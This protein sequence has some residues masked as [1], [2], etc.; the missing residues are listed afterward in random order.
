M[1]RKRQTGRAKTPKTAAREPMEQPQEKKPVNILIDWRFNLIVLLC[2]ELLIVVFFMEREVTRYREKV[3]RRALLEGDYERAY[4]NYRR[5]ARRNF[6]HAGYFKGLGDAA[7]GKGQP[8]VAL[9][10][11]SEAAKRGATG[12]LSIQRA[13]AHYMR[14]AETSDPQKREQELMEYQ[15]YLR[16]AKAEAPTGLRENHTIGTFAMNESDLVEAA[17]YFSRVRA[18]VLRLGVKPNREQ[19]A[20]ID[21]S[22]TL[23]SRIVSEVFQDQDYSLDLEGLEIKPPPKPPAP[24]IGPPPAAPT[25]PTTTRTDPSTTAPKPPPS[26]MPKTAP[27]TMP[28]ILRAPAPPTSP[29]K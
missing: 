5:L 18:D 13:R 21:Q 26:R 9:T 17:E 20:L 7:L 16:A 27:T 10:Y 14:A 25:T 15:R 2:M 29:A 24:V 3:A 28:A 22:R 11:Y 4:R 19:Q 12:G 6:S 8:G 23:L 1:A